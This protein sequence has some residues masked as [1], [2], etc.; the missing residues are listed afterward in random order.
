MA[1]KVPT[2]QEEFGEHIVST[3]R[4]AVLCEVCDAG[5]PGAAALITFMAVHSPVG[6]EK[7]EELAGYLTAWLDTVRT[8]PDPQAWE[9]E[10]Q[11]WRRGEFDDD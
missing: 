5:T 8:T 10:W 3:Y 7:V 6:P 1:V 4:H 9:E 2:S 11:A